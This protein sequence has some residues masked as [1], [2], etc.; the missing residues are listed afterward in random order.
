[1]TKAL[2]AVAQWRGKLAP[3]GQAFLNL[4]YPRTC[5]ACDAPLP[6]VHDA[7]GLPRWFCERC[8]KDFDTV[9]A[10]YCKVCAEPFDGAI[11][12]EFQCGNCS[13]RDLAFDFAFARYRARDPVRE[14]IHQFKYNRDLSL[15]A[16]LGELLIQAL[17]E[18][19]LATEDLS[20]WTLIPVPLHRLRERERQF[21]QSWELCLHVQERLGIEAI[22]AMKRVK[23]TDKQARLTRVQ[24]LQNLRGAFEMK[25]PYGGKGSSLRGA[26][27]FLID[28]VFTTGATTD[29]CARVLKREA[30]VQKVV[31]LAV[32][33]G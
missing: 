13:E 9:E 12:R 25:P 19:R 2:A 28:D 29:A 23:P 22:D 18:P 30:G 11:E 3:W 7:T 20:Q 32:A 33:R 27:V 4:L 21:N 16:A 31:V 26:K 14:L 1:M 10:P 15:R 17:Q 6:T 5:R 8:A 24:R